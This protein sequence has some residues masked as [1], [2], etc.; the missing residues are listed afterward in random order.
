MGADDHSSPGALKPQVIIIT[1]AVS[2]QMPLCCSR[3]FWFISVLLPSLEMRFS[4][5]AECSIQPVSFCFP[6]H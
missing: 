4:I 5:P 3:Q 2:L 1:T 6:F